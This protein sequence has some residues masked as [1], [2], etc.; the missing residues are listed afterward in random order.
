MHFINMF[1][2]YKNL[3]GWK[4]TGSRVGGG[5]YDAQ[6]SAVCVNPFKVNDI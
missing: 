2:D 4:K 3:V 6:F 5:A 1:Q